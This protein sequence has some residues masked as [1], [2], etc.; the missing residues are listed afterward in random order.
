L[1]K[2]DDNCWVEAERHVVLD[3]LGNSFRFV[4]RLKPTQPD[5]PKRTG[6]QQGGSN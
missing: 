3:K 1:V 5:S 2:N 6:P 4:P